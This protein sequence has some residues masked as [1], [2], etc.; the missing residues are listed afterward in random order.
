MVVPGQ[1]ENEPVLSKQRVKAYLQVFLAGIAAEQMRGMTGDAQTI[2]GTDDRRKATNLA[3]KAIVDWGMSE[4]FGLAIPSE[5]T[6]DTT[7]V[8]SEINTWL[9]SAYKDVCELL[10]NNKPLLDKV[11]QALTENEQLD[12]SDIK[13]LFAISQGFHL[14]ATA[15]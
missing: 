1:A 12:K 2:G 5:L 11:S 6:I 7:Q 3:K 15:A 10:A 13:G 14:A 8:N 9:S 4:Q